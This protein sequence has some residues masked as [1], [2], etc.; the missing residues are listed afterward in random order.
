MLASVLRFVFVLSLVTGSL[1]LT[2]REFF[3]LKYNLQ[4]SIRNTSAFTIEK[5][6]GNYKITISGVPEHETSDCYNTDMNCC[7]PDARI[8][9]RAK[10]MIIP[11]S[12][13]ASRTE[14]YCAPMG[15]VGFATSGTAFYNHLEADCVDV[16]SM[17][18]GTF[19]GCNGHP[20]PHGEYHFHRAPNTTCLGVPYDPTTPHI[21]GVAEDG[22]PIYDSDMYDGI[23]Q[24]LDECGGFMPND[25]P[26]QYRYVS[27]F[28]ETNGRDHVV[29]CFKGI[30]LEPR[31]CDCLECGLL[32]L[33]N[34][35][36]RRGQNA[37]PD[38][39]GSFFGG[40]GPPSGGRGPPS[41][42]R[43]PPSGGQGFPYGN[44]P[45]FGFGPP[46]GQR[47]SGLGGSS[48]GF[49]SECPGE[50]RVAGRQAPSTQGTNSGFPFFNFFARQQQATQANLRPGDCTR[51]QLQ[52]GRQQQPQTVDCST[53][54]QCVP[55][56]GYKSFEAGRKYSLCRRQCQGG[57]AKSTIM[58]PKSKPDQKPN[59]LTS[60]QLRSL[61]EQLLRYLRA[62]G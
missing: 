30:P 28:G 38:N 58:P 55:A 46:N 12:P 9:T 26:S 44:R 27:L 59:D 35:T 10:S 40:R 57:P 14:T 29:P 34:C 48:E 61:I 37:R 18:E 5:F 36:N 51:E 39:M 33:P 50:K 4:G 54:D 3:I 47:P 56:G 42:G 17:P 20:S 13:V 52:Q 45:R 49:K 7:R 8:C 60:D 41:G 1:A 25:D 11:R 23:K 24:V 31:C 32:Q 62:Q 6:E 2:D 15:S 43:G 53:C 16:N 19:D 22:F 21:I